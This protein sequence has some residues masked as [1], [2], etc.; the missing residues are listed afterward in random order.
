[1]P[2]PK[3]AEFGQTGL[4]KKVWVTSE[5]GLNRVITLEN[6]KMARKK[7][8]FYPVENFIFKS[9]SRVFS[10]NNQLKS[11]FLQILFVFWL[12]TN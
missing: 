1:L 9:L 5:T 4:L 10:V 2:G 6:F 12:T 3:W 11:N 8:R 7:H